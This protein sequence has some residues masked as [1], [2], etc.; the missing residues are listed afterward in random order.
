MPSQSNKV[1]GGQITTKETSA[2]DQFYQTETK[3]FPTVK[4]KHCSKNFED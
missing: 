1:S 3:P 4:I 2:L